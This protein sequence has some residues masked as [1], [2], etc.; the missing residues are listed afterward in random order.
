MNIG[1]MY[2]GALNRL[3]CLA[4]AVAC[5]TCQAQDVYV[6]S[7]YDELRAML[8]DPGVEII[9]LRADITV[10]ESAKADGSGLYMSGR[11]VEIRGAWHPVHITSDDGCKR[12][13]Y[14]A[15]GGQLILFNIKV[16]NVGTCDESDCHGGGVHLADGSLIGGDAV[17][18]DNCKACGF[19]GA[20]YGNVD[21]D[22]NFQVG[23][24]FT[25]NQAGWAG[26]AVFLENSPD[27]E[28][29]SMV[30]TDARFENNTSGDGTI[31][32]SWWKSAMRCNLR[33]SIG[34]SGH[35]PYC[36]SNCGACKDGYDDVDELCLSTTTTKTT[37]VT[38]TT[39][40]STTAT[41]TT[42]TSTVGTTVLTSTTIVSLDGTTTTIVFP[43]ASTPSMVSTTP[44]GEYKK[45][46]TTLLSATTPSTPS[47][48]DSTSVGASSTVAPRTSTH[49]P[50]GATTPVALATSTLPVLATSAAP[51]ELTSTAWSTSTVPLGTSTSPSMGSSAATT[52][53]PAPPSSSMRGT[54]T[55]V[56][57]TGSASAPWATS[58]T[59]QM[60]GDSTTTLMGPTD[61][62]PNQFTTTAIMDRT[63][64]VTS[65]EVLTM[66]ESTTTIPMSTHSPMKSTTAPPS[67]TSPADP[68]STTE[69]G[70]PTS[71]TTLSSTSDAPAKTEAATVAGSMKLAVD[72]AEAFTNDPAVKTGVQ[73]SIAT[74]ASVEPE[75][76]NL[77]LTV[78]T[79]RLRRL[80]GGLQV[81]VDYTISLTGDSVHLTTTMDAVV[82]K[83]KNVTASEVSSILATKLEEDGVQYTVEVT[84][85][86]EVVAEYVSPGV[87]DL[88]L[89]TSTFA[90]I[91]T[92]LV[93]NVVDSNTEEPREDDDDNS[94]TDSPILP[95]ISQ[96]EEDDDDSI[97]AIVGIA[98][99]VGLVC[100]VIVGASGYCVWKK[101]ARKSKASQDSV[102]LAGPHIPDA[103]PPPVPA[104]APLEPLKE[105]SWPEPAE[106]PEA[107]PTQV[108]PY[109][110]EAVEGV[111]PTAVETMTNI[112]LSFG[113]LNIGGPTPAD[114]NAS[115]VEDP[116]FPEPVLDPD[117][118]GHPN[119]S[120]APTPS[121]PWKA[122]G[123]SDDSGRVKVSL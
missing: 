117:V 114:E 23:A 104:S 72:D 49:S 24:V 74:M 21:A 115:P 35:C 110:G 118:S 11:Y 84:E 61:P 98:I 113:N 40:T 27:D 28:L 12:A 57:D 14:V 64:P 121:W 46:T 111:R 101:T 50:A 66:S 10:A 15:G 95:G 17:I 58:T 82:G 60:K 29:A 75:Q 92:T 119:E 45:S 86:T 112:L 79:T 3:F 51:L 85:M 20:V 89:A 120:R 48:D 32:I 52:T 41:F 73:K 42:V 44:V 69:P 106:F 19:G 81:R 76:V 5:Y 18:W 16:H 38:T 65:T 8:Q 30:T 9:E 80:E 91:S 13:F 83:L 87:V 122:P 7:S 55:T 53:E 56:K 102:A 100:F 34:F 43:S 36:E 123:A 103:P 77:T 68:T 70:E 1:N 93:D 71:T 90:V 94:T 25:N 97:G 2:G 63:D 22:V 108:A 105:A 47:P 107:Q 96:K 33:E 26:G 31:V 99:G 78:E 6:A 67:A 59:I 54:T 116:A 88:N 62:T 109:E 39:S 37:T 4:M